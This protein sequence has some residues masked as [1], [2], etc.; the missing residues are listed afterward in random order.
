MKHV[1]LFAIILLVAS[2]GFFFARPFF[3]DKTDSR[4]DAPTE[5]ATIAATATTKAPREM[6]ALFVGDVMMDRSIRIRAEREQNGYAT[7]FECVAPTFEKYDVVVAN[8]EGS[9]TDFPSVSRYGKIN[10]PES[11][12][13]TMS[14]EI[15][16][17][18]RAVGIDAV[19]VANNHIYDFGRKGLEM[20]RQLVP[21]SGL[22]Y[23]GDPADEAHA[24]ITLL[25]DDEKGDLT[26]APRIH[27][28][29]FNEFVGTGAEAFE[30]TKK[31]LARFA[32]AN[33]PVIVFA[34]WGNEY[35][36]AT[37]RVKE[38]AHQFIDLGADA[39]IG[40]HPHVVQETEYY[41]GVF[42]AYSLGNFIFDQYF[43]AEVRKGAAVELIIRDDEIVES[44]L[45]PVSLNENR[46]PC[47]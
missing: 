2:A 18:L 20:T 46:L 26:K 21:A 44:R 6:R 38:W 19:G 37:E 33:E 11:F 34:H 22:G 32:D 47:I 4:A 30:K 42:I 24:S 23:F 17:V 25:V 41:K 31:E 8:L 40:H 5:L 9:V 35:V 13:F 43:D 16:P 10:T 3:F 27:I 15:L 7:F 1:F 39:V 29:T 45:L 36:P 12:Q 14:P 28:V